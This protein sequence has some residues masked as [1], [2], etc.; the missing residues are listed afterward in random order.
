MLSE[1][2]L[3]AGLVGTL[4]GTTSLADAGAT[5]V[6]MASTAPDTAQVLLSLTARLEHP[7][8]R[9]TIIRPA[10]PDVPEMIM[11]T[12][13]TTAEDLQAA[14]DMLVY[15]RHSFGKTVER[16]MVAHV[17]AAAENSS[18]SD[19]LQHA[20]ENLALL[21]GGQDLQLPGFGS[22]KSVFIKVA[23]TADI[24]GGSGGAAPAHAH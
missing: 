22:V 24:E 13:A 14:L 9:A 11:V 4:A 16:E 17:P 7:D 21:P 15:A 3:L 1:L 23:D 2:L 8:A 20:R 18:T 5:P 6:H 10:G 19:E 12:P